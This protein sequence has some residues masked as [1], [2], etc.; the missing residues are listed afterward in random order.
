MTDLQSLRLKTRI[1]L[2][3]AD[4][5]DALYAYYALYHDPRRTQITIHEDVEGHPDGFAAVCQT[6]QRLF[7]PTVAL[8]ARNVQTAIAVLRQALTPGR[9][10]TVITT[11]DLMDATA[12]VLTIERAEINHIYQIE[13]TRFQPAINVLV[14][15][16]EGMGGLP[17]FVIRSQAAAS[18][19]IA[20]ESSFNWA[21]PHFAEVFVRVEPSARGRGWGH[22]V[23]A[24]STTW[25]IHSARLPIYVVNEANEPGIALAQSSG[26]VDTGAREFT[27]EGVCKSGD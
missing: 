7:Q 6:G 12:E 16:E 17:R 26:Y 20:A 11:L 19:T 4:P 22:A 3:L 1:M 25:A 2:H 21:S 23:L 10:Y 15:T 5:V 8:R 18:G 14:V 13:P 9:P 27:G 24:A